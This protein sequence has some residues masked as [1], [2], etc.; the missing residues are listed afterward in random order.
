MPRK[1]MTIRIK[2]PR[3]AIISAFHAPEPSDEDK[4]RFAAW[5]LS[6]VAR[7]LDV[8]E[9]ELVYELGDTNDRR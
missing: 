3:R 5:L 6:D 9:V 1:A 2:D 8:D 4:L 7:K